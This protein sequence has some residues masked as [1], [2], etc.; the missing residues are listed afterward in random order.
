MTGAVQIKK[1]SGLFIRKKQKQVTFRE[2]RFDMS[3]RY[4]FFP[5]EFEKDY[6]LV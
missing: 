6:L 5:T 4:I 1:T 3:N 2:N